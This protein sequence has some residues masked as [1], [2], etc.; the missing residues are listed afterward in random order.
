MKML[1]RLWEYGKGYRYA[2]ILLPLAILAQVGL[3]T[4]IPYL[5]GE[6]LDSGIYSGDLN[7]ILK[8]GGRMALASVGVK[9]RAVCPHIQ[10]VAISAILAAGTRLSIFSLMEVEIRSSLI[11]ML[12]VVCFTFPKMSFC[13]HSSVSLLRAEPLKT[14][15]QVVI[16]FCIPFFP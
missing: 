10:P 8:Q 15:P 9:S 16:T 13:S 12:W 2:M 5:M 7:L 6:M 4:W 11:L 14:L 3:E 1:G